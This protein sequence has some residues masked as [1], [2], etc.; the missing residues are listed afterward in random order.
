MTEITNTTEGWAGGGRRSWTGWGR[1]VEEAA[2]GPVRYGGARPGP[3][4][5]RAR[6]GLTLALAVAA[7]WL[8]HGLYHKLLAGAPRHLAIVQSVPLLGGEVGRAVLLAVGIGEVALAIWVIT[9]WRPRTAAAVQTAALLAMNVMELIWAREHLLWPAGLLPVNALFLAAAW[10]AALWRGPTALGRHVLQRHPLPVR[11][12]FEHCLVLTYAL[13]RG[14]LEPLLPPGLTLDTR[15]EWGFA[16]V[17]MVQTRRLRP[18]F[19]PRGLGQD[20]FLAGYRLFV[21]YRTPQGR[22]LRGLYILGSDADR[23]NMVIGGNLL[24]HYRYRKCAARVQRSSA[25]MAIDVF[26][27]DGRGDVSLSADL[28]AGA[29]L[30]IGSPFATWSDAR[31]FAGP[32]PYTFD[33]EPQTGSIIV[34]RGE[35]RQWRPRPV[36]VQVER[37]T[38]FDSLPLGGSRPVL[39]AAFA[40]DHIEY[41]WRRG[42]RHPLGGES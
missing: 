3:A 16:A 22:T 25:A 11:A 18:T 32:L 4:A 27:R 21:K 9:G 14:V 29:G 1:A 13:P 5:W 7:V 31:A 35:R 42:V 40:V 37:L 28:S 24:T 10:A 36:Q 17:A 41:R 30:P 15:G 23:W 19:L 6:L 20:F 38:F 26:S 12:R 2:A 8:W 34:I 33:H 39:A